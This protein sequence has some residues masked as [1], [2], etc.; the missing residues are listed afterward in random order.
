MGPLLWLARWKRRLVAP[1][2]G[3]LLASTLSSC[4][5]W[6]TQYSTTDGSY[7]SGIS[8]PSA[9]TCFAVGST[10]GVGSSE[11]GQAIL[12]ETS[13]AGA[14]WVSLSGAAS[15]TVALSAIAC[16]DVDHCVA[17]G[18]DYGNSTSTQEALYT[19]DGGAT[20]NESA[21]LV[22]DNLL[23]S[24]WCLNDDDCWV[25]EGDNSS[26]TQVEFTTDSGTTWSASDTIEP[27]VAGTTNLGLDN[28][29]CPTASECLADG[30]GTYWDNDVPYPVPVTY[31]V[32][33]S[34]TD[35]GM[36][37]QEQSLPSSVSAG[38]IACLSPSD[39]L[40]TFGTL[41][42][43]DSGVTWNISS[44][45]VP[46]INTTPEAISCPSSLQCIAVGSGEITA[47][48]DT[49]VYVTDDGGETWSIQPV[50][51]TAPEVNLQAVS[52]PTTALCWAAGYT[53][54]ATAEDSG[55]LILHTVTGGVAWPSI[56]S[57][58]PTQGPATG[59]TKVT[60]S[61]AG[62]FGSPTVTFGTG[63]GAVTATNVS[64]VSTN[65]LQVTVPSCDCVP[66]PGGVPVQVTVSE[67]GLGTSPV[68]LNYLFTYESP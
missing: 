19:T 58:S 29:V 46:G 28:I 55:S 50:V 4:L 13:N 23:T 14:T 37:W 10:Q 41:T 52:C 20:W 35:G 62:F 6:F 12:E 17:V 47:G 1:I 59:G 49:A 5:G 40:T 44:V 15:G 54:S 65:E 21:P 60:I 43:S 63:P 39:C 33:L 3:L 26:T 57:I 27:P 32:L 38:P 30:S 16:P 64:V 34:S 36:T 11:P 66:A 7:L 31:P 45:T 51:V 2:G 25:T 22:A 24:V 48:A 53:T 68:N 61:G 8:C 18:G 56:G 42:T 67:P 9:M